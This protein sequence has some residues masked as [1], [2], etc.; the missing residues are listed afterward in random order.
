MFT[1]QFEEAAAFIAK[2]ANQ[3]VTL[4]LF[5]MLPRYLS[6]QDWRFLDQPAVAAELKTSRPSITRGMQELHAL[7]VLE[8]RGTKVRTEWRLSP[9]FGWRGTVEGYDAAAERRRIFDIAAPPHAP[10]IVAEG[11]SGQTG[12][13]STTKAEHVPSPR[14][15]NLTLPRVIP[16]GKQSARP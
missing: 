7:G 16:G 3:P 12:A 14:Q 13:P 8:R 10:S 5:L 4:R 2:N 1:V 15:R 6:Y 11:I 9:D